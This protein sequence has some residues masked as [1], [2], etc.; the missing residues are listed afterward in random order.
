MMLINKYS[1]RSF[2]DAS[3]Y[4]IFPWIG[5]WGWDGFIEITNIN[6]D[7]LNS[8]KEEVSRSKEYLLNQ[9]QNFMENGL[10]RNLHKNWGK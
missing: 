10:I 1:S 7:L 4:P 2:N 8:A 9:E 5:P 3:Q 6:S